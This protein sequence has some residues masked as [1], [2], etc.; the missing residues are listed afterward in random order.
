M[1]RT[2]RVRKG[3]V[4]GSAWQAAYRGLAAAALT[5]VSVAFQ[6]IGV[7]AYRRMVEVELRARRV[8][9]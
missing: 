6:A 7:W 8:G 2:L 1:C 9:A 4:M 5:L 3:D